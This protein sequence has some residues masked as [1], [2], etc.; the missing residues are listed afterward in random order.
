[1]HGKGKIFGSR[2]R[3]ILPFKMFGVILQSYLTIAKRLFHGVMAALEFLVLSVVVRI[4][5]EQLHFQ[6][7][8]NNN[9]IVAG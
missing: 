7:R 8:S 9:K 6:P 4:G 2:S 3:K 1:M 5:V